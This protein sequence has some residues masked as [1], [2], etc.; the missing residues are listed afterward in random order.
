MN[1][2]TL[3][4]KDMDFKDQIVEFNSNIVGLKDFTELVEPVL[5]QRK[6]NDAVPHTLRAMSILENVINY[7]PI[8]NTEKREILINVKDSIQKAL[9]LIPNSGRINNLEAVPFDLST[10]Y[11]LEE[12]WGIPRTITK[13]FILPSDIPKH[14]NNLYR[15]NLIS[16][17]S[18]IEW[19][20]AQLLH[21]FYDRHPEAPGINKKPLTFEELKSF[22]SIND[23]EKYLVE[24]KIENLLRGSIES[25][26][27][28]LK[29]DLNLK[30]NFVKPYMTQIIE[31]SQRR[32]LFVHNAGFVNNMYLA[33][34]DTTLTGFQL[35]QKLLIDKSYLEK[36]INLMQVTF[37]LLAAE[38]WKKLN[39][40]DLD[41]GRLLQDIAFDFLMQQR[42]EDVGVITDFMIKDLEQE[43]NIKTVAQ[44]N[45]WL[46]IKK[47]G[48]W[49]SIKSTIEKLDY[50]DKQLIYQVGL[51][52]LKDDSNTF[53]S[54][55][56]SCITN[57]ELSLNN[58]ELFPIFEDMVKQPA[59]A[60]FKES[61]NKSLI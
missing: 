10:I 11:A 38:L 47:M 34:V 18:S 5:L 57:E 49:E 8:E 20:F 61:I 51:A 50:S 53:Y 54:L 55:L 13:E 26:F 42:W 59:W 28:Y 56:P 27:E 45:N 2:V 52:A 15:N 32:N 30:L 46:S 40:N 36:S 16:L 29:N 4:F 17:L 48:K 37:T 35:N 22:A 31:I 39:P 1:K 33:K 12:K 43:A 14:I 44:L 6:E 19:F 60:V 24:D 9:N 25:W 7:I 23:A 41:R 58:V 3:S 21:I